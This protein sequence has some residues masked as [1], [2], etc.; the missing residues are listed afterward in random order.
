[1]SFFSFFWVL[2]V[3][4]IE[5]RDYPGHTSLVGGGVSSADVYYLDHRTTLKDG[6]SAYR[7]WGTKD[8]E[9]RRLEWCGRR[10]CGTE[11]VLRDSAHTRSW[12]G[13]QRDAP[14]ARAF[15]NWYDKIRKEY[16]EQSWLLNRVWA[17]RVH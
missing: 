12:F 5:R 17:W 16:E 14:D 3:P 2:T 10:T 7:W 6:G 11:K 4:I 15:Q 8:G 9:W 1:M 13:I